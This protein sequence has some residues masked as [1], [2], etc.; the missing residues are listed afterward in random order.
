MTRDCGHRA[1]IVDLIAE[2]PCTEC[3]LSAGEATAKH[4]ELPALTGTESQ[5]RWAVTIRATFSETLAATLEEIAD[6][7][8]ASDPRSAH[9]L[10]AASRVQARLQEWTEAKQWIDNRTLTPREA[11][12]QILAG[13]VK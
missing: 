13:E 11:I 8:S 6:K 3:Q 9:V 2:T 4:S 1:S 5:V 7:A 10:D 12:R